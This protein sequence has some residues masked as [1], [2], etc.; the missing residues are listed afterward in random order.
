MTEEADTYYYAIPIPE[1]VM[2]RIKRLVGPTN[3]NVFYPFKYNFEI[4]ETTYTIYLARVYVA[5]H[6][7]QRNG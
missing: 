6:I 1:C 7:E 4:F 2:I 5:Y 3:I